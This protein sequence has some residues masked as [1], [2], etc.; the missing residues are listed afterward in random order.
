MKVEYTSNTLWGKIDF[1]NSGN[2]RLSRILYLDYPLTGLM[3]FFW[4]GKEIITGSSVPMS[5]RNIQDVLTAIKISMRPGERQTLYFKRNSQHTFST[6]FFLANDLEFYKARMGHENKFRFYL[7]A[8]GALI[9]YNLFLAFFF[10]E[11][12][13]YLYCG[14]VVLFLLSVLNLNGVL[15]YI[16]VFRSTTLSH[17]LI[18]FSS[19]TTYMALS[20][21]YTFLEGSHYL[22]S[23]MPMKRVL[24]VLSLLPAFFAP[25]R[26]YLNHPHY[27]GFYI[28]AVIQV[29]LIFLIISCFIAMKK[30]SPLAKAYLVSWSCVFSGAFL[31]FGHTYGLFGKNALTENG[32]LFGSIGEMI[33][34]SLGLAYKA[35]VV[36]QELQ[37]SQI[38]AQGK[39]KYQQLLRTV[40]HDISNSLMVLVAGARRLKKL[41]KNDMVLNI[42]D[43]MAFSNQNLLEILEQIKTQEKLLQDNESIVLEK[44]NLLEVLN[45][46]FMIFE[47]SLIEKNI[48][49][50]MNIPPGHQHVM[51][52]KIS[53]KNNV[54]GNIFSNS[55]KYSSSDSTIQ[56]YT[57]D[58][59][60]R[61]ALFIKDQGKGFS[62]EALTFLNGDLKVTFSTP[63]TRGEQGTGFGLR[64]I[65]NY[66]GLYQARILAY[67]DNGA[68]F[69]IQ[70]K[71]D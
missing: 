33:I 40:S 36:D 34:L 22:V 32:L 48:I 6:K 20:F 49:V 26:V 38:Q 55:I 41:S 61:V 46:V 8:M 12:K 16:E 53:L 59:G 57:H 24:Q 18:I 29:S 50:K 39:E 64:I 14:F 69:K 45:E 17:Y 23:L 47:D 35:V 43:K 56:I 9:L 30:G 31:Y 71:K 5:Q 3:S 27:F 67:N 4:K 7:G 11:S 52:E 10:K 28:D 21:G 1:I 44:V 42:A 13:Y 25:T 63:G 58:E 15:D 19:L 2:E 66:L 51:A 60:E 54:L 62:Q 70:F 68:V 65:K 37:K